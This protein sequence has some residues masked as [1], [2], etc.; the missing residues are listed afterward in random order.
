MI[1]RQFE[2]KVK[3]IRTDNAKDF[4][5]NEF[6]HYY[7]EL[8]IVH[9]T[10]YAYTP[11]QNGVAERK[12]GIIE[13]KGIALLIHINAPTFLWGEATLT[14]TYLSNRLASHSLGYKSP[15]QLLSTAVPM[16]KRGNDFPKRIFGCECYMHLYP[17]QTTKLVP[18]SIKCVFVG[19]SNTQKG[20]KCYYPTGREII[21]FKDVTFNELKR[22]YLQNQDTE[23]LPLIDQE[24]GRPTSSKGMILQ[25][26]NV[27]DTTEKDRYILRSE[28][29]PA[30]Y[31]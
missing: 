13:E 25:E 31:I 20:Y 10:S 16:I 18:K 30:D 1:D 6:Y 4:L 12:I 26:S 29:E 27:A 5:N 22:F 9:E 8:G 19:Y 28:E 21:T 15:M 23:S 2:Q 24:S 14:A 3:V 7:N 11:Q 17:T